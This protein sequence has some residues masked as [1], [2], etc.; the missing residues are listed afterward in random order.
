MAIIETLLAAFSI[1]SGSNRMLGTL[2]TSCRILFDTDVSGGTMLNVSEGSVEYFR[3]LLWCEDV[4]ESE[5]VASA[6]LL[7]FE[8]SDF[9]ILDSCGEGC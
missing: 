4:L 5:S 2:K 6:S 9:S 3:R 8:M 7:R 1:S